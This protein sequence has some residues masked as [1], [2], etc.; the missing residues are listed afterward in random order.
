MIE[1][2][3]NTL[4]LEKKIVRLAAFTHKSVGET[5]RQEG[6]LLSIQLARYTQP[7]GFDESALAKGQQAIKSDLEGTRRGGSGYGA[8]FTVMPD[9]IMAQAQISEASGTTQNLKLF[10]RKDGTVY[11]TDRQTFK[12]FASISEMASHHQSLRRSDGSV[13]ELHATVEDIGRWKFINTW[14]IGRTQFNNYL[15]F[16]FQK[17]GIAKSG[18]AS[19]AKILGSTRGIP[20]WVTRHLKDYGFGEVI[21]RTNDPKPTLTLRNNINYTSQVLSTSGQSGAVRDSEIRLA[22]RIQEALDHPPKE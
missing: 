1:V 15:Q 14:V 9:D 20:G 8:V 11:G 18:W 13:G 2:T 22:K 19:C 7:F 3:V 5:M 12:P 21:D 6:R 10:A 4:G 16:V 17:V